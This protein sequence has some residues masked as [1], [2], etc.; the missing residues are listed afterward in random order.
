M[1]RWVEAALMAAVLLTGAA[2]AAAEPREGG[3][4]EQLVAMSGG[5]YRDPALARYLRTVGARLV[6]AAGQPAARWTFTVLDTPETNAFALPGRRIFVTRGMLALVG[7]EAELATVLSHEIAH[8]LAGDGA[9]AESPR[10]RRAAEVAADRTGLALLMRAGY[11]PGAQ[12]DFLTTLLASRELDARLGGRVEDPR[13]AAGHPALADRLRAAHRE[14]GTAA[15]RGMRNRAAY[16][17]AIDG[18]TWGD[19]P[20]QGFVR[21]R[22]FVHPD[23][24]FA[25]DTPAGYRVA[26]LPDAVVAS[27]PKGAMLLMDSVPDPGG[28]PADY[29]ARGWVPE[30]AR[31]IRAGRLEALRAGTLNGLAMAEGRLA[32]ASARSQ[33]VAELTV[34]RLDDRLYRLTGLHQPGDAAA[35]AALT[36]A[37]RSFRPLSRAEAARTAPR[38]LR[39]HRI[40]R[41]ED[42]AALAAGMPVGPAARARFDVINGLIA[43]GTLRAGDLVKV[44]AE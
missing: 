44:V 19:G 7:D 21:G 27:G 26:N 31:A 38:R 28:S 22:S 15:G 1:S 4:A 12:A 33:R 6:T 42:V 36:V 20:A 5:V 13:G 17:A 29:L 30:I 34:V 18:M 24:G 2:P 9:T 8:S 14:A 40:A 25:F 43:D 3:T 11:D 10:A 23:L 37:A 16:L 35:R 39:I 41:G 32:M